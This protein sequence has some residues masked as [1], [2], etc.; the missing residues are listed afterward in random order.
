MY[1]MFF[2]YVLYTIKKNHNLAEGK[3]QSYSV[4]ILLEK[5][6]LQK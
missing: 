5:P 2:K 1:I 4:L 3:Q 6:F